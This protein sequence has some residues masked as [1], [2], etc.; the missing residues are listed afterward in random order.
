M[1]RITRFLG[2]AGLVSFLLGVSA[3]VPGCGST[4]RASRLARTPLEDTEKIVYK[5]MSLKHN[6]AVMEIVQDNVNEMLRVRGKVKNMGH[7][8]VNAEV[9]VK[10]IDKDGMEIG[11]GAPWMP[12]PVER[13]E[14]RTFEGVAASKLAVDWRILVQL[15]GS[16]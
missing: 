12:L 6:L 16:H 9:K 7:G 2:L 1:L 14:I 8:M 4:Y 11:Q 10:F 13:G 15:A 5:D 3:L